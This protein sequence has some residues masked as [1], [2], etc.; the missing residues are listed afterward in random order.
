M[1]EM[2]MSKA[3]FTSILFTTAE[4]EWEQ[5]YNFEYQMNFVLE[6]ENIYR[7]FR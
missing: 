2:W 1:T 3:L 5:V 4:N 7:D 6:T